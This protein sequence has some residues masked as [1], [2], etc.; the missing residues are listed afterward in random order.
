[1]AVI[2]GVGFNRGEGEK[3]LT[4][5]F[6]DVTRAYFYAEAKQDIKKERE[7]SAKS[8]KKAKEAGSKWKTALAQYVV[9]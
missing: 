8:L 1:M 4:V 7:E 9:F 5:A 2:E 6:I 3:G